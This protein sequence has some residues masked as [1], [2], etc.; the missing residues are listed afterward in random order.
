MAYRTIQDGRNRQKKDMEDQ[1]Q[2]VEKY[3]RKNNRPPEIKSEELPNLKIQFYDT[4]QAAAG[5]LNDV[6][7][8]VIFNALFFMGA[9]YFFLRYDVR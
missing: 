4:G 9:F 5:A 3:W 7:L 1:W 8:L 2:A 6:L